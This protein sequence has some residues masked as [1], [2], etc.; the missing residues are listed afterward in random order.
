[1]KNSKKILKYLSIENKE[2]LHMTCNYV[3]HPRYGGGI[4][5]TSQ[6]GKRHYVYHPRYREALCLPQYHPRFRERHLVLLGNVRGGAFSNPR[7]KKLK[8]RFIGSV[9]KFSPS[10]LFKVRSI[11]YIVYLV[12]SIS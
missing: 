2:N 3:Y 1:M 4:I 7:N 6:Y 9:R 11:D 5:S 8:N 12:K 10:N